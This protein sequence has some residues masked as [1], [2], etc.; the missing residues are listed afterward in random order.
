MED[1]YLLMSFFY[2]Y[3]LVAVLLACAVPATLAL[4]WIV[5]KRKNKLRY[6]VFSWAILAS[7]L[8]LGTYYVS[9]TASVTKAGLQDRL[10]GLAKS[11]AVA[12][13]YAG[14]E[15]VTFDA[16]TDDP[17]YWNMID[18]MTKW[19]NQIPFAAS[20][21]TFRRNANG[22]IA[23]VCCP[24]ADLNRDGRI[25]GEREQLTRKGKV[26]AV[27][28]AE[29]DED[30][31]D[32][33]EIEDEEDIPEIIDAFNGKS[34]FNNIPTDD[35]WGL[36]I[37][38]AEPIFV[39]D[40]DGNYVLDENGEKRV[41]AVLGVDFWGE[42]WNENITRA[43]LWPQLFLLLA[44]ILFFAVQ[45]F[46]LRQ[47]IVADRLT[48]YAANLEQVMDE[49]VVA[50][51]EADSA[52]YAKSFFLANISHEIRTPLNA[53]LGGADMLVKIDKGEPI[54][55]NREQL[56]HIMR[57][58]CTQ[59]MMLIDDV[60]TFSNI[61]MNRIVLESAPIDLRQLIDDVKMMSDND[62][63]EKP[64][65]EFRSEFEGSVPQVILGDPVR[66]RQILFC[67]VSNAI[68][69][70]SSGH[71]TVRCSTQSPAQ[72]K[73][74]ATILPA[75]SSRIETWLPKIA[76]ARGLREN[77]LL[78]EMSEQQS[79]QQ[80]SLAGT[81]Q[82]LP[83]AATFLRIDVS[84]TGIGIDQN[85]F[86]V[87]FQP[88]LQADNTSTRQFGGTG[89]GLSI[90]KG[91]VQLMGGSVQVESALGYGSTFS[92]IIPL[93]EYT[94]SVFRHDASSSAPMELLPLHNYHILVVDDVAVNRLVIEA[95]LRGMG[96]KV[97]CATNGQAAMD[98]VLKA[99][100]LKSSF[101]LVLM[102]LQMPIM[103][104]FEATQTLRQRGYQKPIVALT[105]NHHSNEEALAAGCNHVLWKPVDGE[106]LCKTITHYV[107]ES[108]E[109][110]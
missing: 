21:Y 8:S 68:K 40:A 12:L 28:G 73:Q 84:D 106:N 79:I 31:D 71:V 57:K 37:T 27:G 24:P 48:E 47:Q 96:A 10:V 67:L 51:K 77:L 108:K 36:W 29:D 75:E 50:K 89:L 13:Q 49:L 7:I 6:L 99:E 97:Q 14:H 54:S 15:K 70:T 102:D 85:M 62:L 66:L 92:V 19:Q 56:T 91:L 46:I 59:L 22:N 1:F 86:D 39:F 93:S 103:D 45:I 32:I 42:D 76:Y 80:Q 25:E 87:L 64:D 4:T 65:V 53:I 98:A 78:A 52:A 90:T 44:T 33:E 74:P 104:G 43:V 17:L 38:A 88:F 26:Y 23:F 18:M 5:R 83:P 109:K 81:L 110:R 60:L 82:H 55:I 3:P 105:A 107:R 2:D 11:F 69:F 72:S 35:G 95:K 34:G 20:I 41:D 94:E 101:D 63:M 30:I 100:E 61:D 16:P 9:H 58:S